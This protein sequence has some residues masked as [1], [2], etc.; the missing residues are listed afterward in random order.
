MATNFWLGTANAVKQI[1]FVTITADDAATTYSITIGGKVVSIL[2]TGTGVNDTAAALQVALAAETEP[3]FTAIVWTVVTD[4]ITATALVAGVEFTATSSV[5]GGTGTISGFGSTQALAGPNVWTTPENWS[6]GVRPVGGDDV[7]IQDSSINICWGLS[8]G[9]TINSL[10]IPKSYTGRIG[11]DGRSFATSAD[12]NTV[13]PTEVE[14]R[15]AYLQIGATTVDIGQDFSPAIVAG[16]DRIL[17]DNNVATTMTIHNTA[18]ASSDVGRPAIR[19]KTGNAACD[20]FVRLAPGGVG[21]AVEDPT[22]IMTI[23]TLSISEVGS[24]S[25]VTTGLGASITTW[26]Q[27]GGIN[28]INTNNDITTITVDG[29]TLTTEGTFQL[30]T[31]NISGGLW[32]SNHTNAGDSIVTLNARGGSV[33]TL[34]S[35]EPRT[36]GIVNALFGSTLRI[37]VSFL[38]ITTLNVDPTR[39]VEI[40]IS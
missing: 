19:F 34:D 26:E 10:T 15:P 11:L 24:I 9:I 35:S 5:V 40:A 6:L 36:L 7:F 3:Y 22:E 18:L 28:I 20:I 33:N 37:D 17:L 27:F 29:G 1:D 32:N 25:Q 14:Y 39:P 12:A 16:S 38:T 2:G 23:R 4:T 21:L 13:D 8:A 31:G 30:T